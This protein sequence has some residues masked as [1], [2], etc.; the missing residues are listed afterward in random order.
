MGMRIALSWF[1]GKRLLQA[2]GRFFRG[3]LV[4]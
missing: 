1:L 3:L 4:F 2:L